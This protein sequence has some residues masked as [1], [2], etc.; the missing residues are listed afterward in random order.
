MIE[1]TEKRALVVGVANDQSIAWGVAQALR[2]AG[3]ELAITYL[4]AKAEPYVR[5]L[6]ESVNAPIIMPLDVTREED[7]EPLFA[8]IKEIWSDLDILIHSIAYAPG[9]DL[10]GRVLDASLPGFSTAMDVSVHSF[11]RLARRAEPLM[12]S[13]GACLAMSFYGAQKVVTNYNLMGPVK[14]AL[15]ATTRELASELGPH[16]I[17]VNVLSPG[18]I[19]TRA[20]GGLANFNELMAEAVSRSPMRRLATIEDVGAAAAFLS[21]DLAR[22]ITGCVLHV[23]G[24][25]HIMG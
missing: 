14:A 3:A 13:G 16:N 11:I 23:D 6:A 12:T 22:N 5:P 18:P 4:N 19:A 10:Q 7:E 21:S 17:T 24:G 8:R 9:E 25:R 1:L 2:R 20:A 15:E